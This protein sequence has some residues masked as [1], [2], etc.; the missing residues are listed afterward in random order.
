MTRMTWVDLWRDAPPP[1]PFRFASDIPA[2]EVIGRAVKASPGEIT[3]VAIGPLTNIALALRLYPGLVS[4]VARIVIMGGVFNVDGYLV[5]TNF[6]FDPEAAAIVLGS[7]APITLIPMDVT[8]KTMLTH[9]DLDSI[10]RLDSP[11]TR[12]L[13]PTLRPWVTYSAASRNIDGMW[14]HDVVAVALLLDPTLG[15]LQ[16]CSV[17]VD[18]AISPTR[19]RTARW[20]PGTLKTR[21]VQRFSEPPTIDVLMDIDNTRLLHLITT[22]LASFRA[23]AALPGHEPQSHLSR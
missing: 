7:G 5:D 17:S 20:T 4:D 18:L 10:E 12:A 16:K 22:Y 21:G 15:T 14:I 9:K 2:A 23:N 6:G 8:T 1:A 19:G 3:I 13:I 11:L